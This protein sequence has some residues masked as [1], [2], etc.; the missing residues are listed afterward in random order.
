MAGNNKITLL[1]NDAGQV[2]KEL[3]E[4]IAEELMVFECFNEEAVDA[5]VLAILNHVAKGNGETP[6]AADKAMSGHIF[7][8][9][10]HGC[11][12]DESNRV[13]DGCQ[14]C[15]VCQGGLSICII[16][17]GA[18]GSL[19]TVCAGYK[20]GMDDQV[21]K[22]DIDYLADGWTKTTCVWFE[23]HVKHVPMWDDKPKLDGF[24]ITYA[25]GLF[26]AHQCYWVATPILPRPQNAHQLGD[27]IREA[28]GG[29]APVGKVGFA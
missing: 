7:A 24:D 14:S 4:R 6:A 2:D 13:T 3:H 9:H 19:T 12:V 17:G 22:G 18:E 25:P 21:Y 8:K 28:R 10:D 29:D 23:N 11:P 16:C 26:P 20:H 27:A 5:I 1:V 15:S